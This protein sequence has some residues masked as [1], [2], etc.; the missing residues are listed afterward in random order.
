MGISMRTTFSI[1]FFL[2][3]ATSL[4][5]QV[6]W[7]RMLSL[8]FG[9]DVYAAA[10][11]LAVFMGG[12][13]LGA[14]ISGRLSDGLK[15]PILAYGV[16]EIG[17]ALSALSFHFLL[18]GFVDLYRE[19]Y[20]SQFEVNPLLYHGFRFLVS[21]VALL[22]PTV[23]MGATLPLVIRQF[24]Y[25]PNFLGSR[26]GQ[27]YALNTFGAFTGTL[28]AGFV[29]I[30]QFGVLN[31]IYAAVVINTAI[32]FLAII[33]FYG[34]AIALPGPTSGMASSPPPKRCSPSRAKCDFGHGPIGLCCHGPG[35]RVDAYSCSVIQRH[36]LRIFHHVGKF[37]LR[38]F[39]WKPHGITNNR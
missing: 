24:A 15:Q 26:V 10:I 33:L 39:L 29:M 31:T 28:A 9:S 7:M 22:I 32:G 11:T 18:G 6:S 1:I 13:S 23:L 19:I 20:Q 35:G 17:I 8:L 27:F 38:N 12:I 2:S 30:P 14:W 16:C 34:Q 3:G 25:K 5:Y 4:V 36:S 21:G 37:P